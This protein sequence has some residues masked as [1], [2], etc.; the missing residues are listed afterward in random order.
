M[1]Q[2]LEHWLSIDRIWVRIL[3]LPFRN[4]GNC[5]SSHC[6]SS[7]CSSSLGGVY[8]NQLSSR[9]NCSKA[10]CFPE[11]SSLSW[12]ERVCQGVKYE[13]LRTGQRTGCTF[14][15]GGVNPVQFFFIGIFIFMKHLNVYN[16][17]DVVTL[18][19]ILCVNLC[20]Y[21]TLPNC[22][23]P[24]LPPPRGRTN[25]WH[26]GCLPPAQTCQQKLPLCHRLDG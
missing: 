4:L 22:F 26:C 2:W 5:S 14:S 25:Q 20:L 12:G 11:K 15:S 10:E 16:F 7:H 6:S 23:F 17:V 19:T 24:G 1:A 18:F 3:L 13:V 9:S 21:P 8:V